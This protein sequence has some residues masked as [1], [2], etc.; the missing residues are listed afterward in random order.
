MKASTNKCHL[1]MST[2]KQP[3]LAVGY[4]SIKKV[5]V[6]RYWGWKLIQNLT[7]MTKFKP[8]AVRPAMN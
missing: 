5:V 1:I 6:N 3:Q 4:S 8:Y 2:D 7:L